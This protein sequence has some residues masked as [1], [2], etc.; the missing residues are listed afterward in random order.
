MT[1]RLIA[2]AIVGLLAALLTAAPATPA[3]AHGQDA[4]TAKNLK[5][6]VNP[7]A[8]A[9]VTV[10]AVEAGAR[11]ELTNHSAATVEILGSY[12]EPFLR[13]RPDG[14]DEH[15]GAGWRATSDRPVVRWHEE[16]AGAPGWSVPLLVDGV[17]AAIRGTV[18]V[19]P[20]PPVTAWW[21]ATLV[22]AIAGVLAAR[23]RVPLAIVLGAVAIVVTVAFAAAA[24]T[25]GA[26]GEFASQLL[27]RGWSLLA[28]LAVL[29]AG[30]VSGRRRADLAV[31]ATAGCAAVAAG[32]AHSGVFANAVIAGPGWIRPAVALV[33]GLGAGL[34]LVAARA[35]YRTPTSPGTGAATT[36]APS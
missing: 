31:A 4:P 30:L 1:A 34:T 7:V 29:A 27:A 17:P 24:T 36:T 15:T 20:A 33:I 8:V 3:T 19:P 28:G 10:R 32:L 12:G 35:W 11:L 23:I 25:P 18:V 22:L 5:V 6:V 13:V 16:R 2:G 26:A 14:V 21:T 9:G